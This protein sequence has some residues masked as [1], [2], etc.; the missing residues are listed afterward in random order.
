MKGQCR[1]R[2][3]HKQSHQSTSQPVSFG[4]GLNGIV[5]VAATEPKSHQCRSRCPSQCVLLLADISDSEPDSDTDT[6]T[7]RFPSIW[8]AINQL[9]M[10]EAIPLKIR[11]IVCDRQVQFMCSSTDECR[12]TGAPESGSVK[13]QFSAREHTE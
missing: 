3:K 8:L 12:K 11:Y 9:E 10:A 2:D 5:K 13:I 1:R 4:F 7:E 6:D